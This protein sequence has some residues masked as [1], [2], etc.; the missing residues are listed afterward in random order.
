MG[1]VHNGPSEDPEHASTSLF[2]SARTDEFQRPSRIICRDGFLLNPNELRNTDLPYTEAKTEVVI[3]RITS[4]AMPRTFERVPAGAKFGVNIVIN[5][6]DE[7]KFKDQLQTLTFK[8]L[9][10]L[11]DDYL[12]GSGSRG[13]GQ[14]KFK[15]TSVIERP[16]SFYHGDGGE[17][18]ITSS[19]PQDLR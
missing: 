10:L 7:D 8:S 5:I 12:G 11:Q 17:K 16:S 14:V 9:Q 15:I 13:S 19:V 1:Q 2:G 4:A 6:F 3:D 18:D